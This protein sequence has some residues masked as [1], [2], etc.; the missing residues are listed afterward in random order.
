MHE[1]TSDLMQNTS[2]RCTQPVKIPHQ[3]NAY[4]DELLQLHI[5]LIYC[6]M[7]AVLKYFLQRLV[8]KVSS[9]RN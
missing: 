2:H 9:D 8:E 7:A 1:N 6:Y 5:T 3:R 4:S